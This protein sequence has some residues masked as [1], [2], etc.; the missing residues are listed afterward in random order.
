MVKTDY[1]IYGMIHTFDF[2]IK[3]YYKIYLKM[4]KQS[5]GIMEV[6]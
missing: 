4:Y 2:R 6:I 5:H 3:M 1:I